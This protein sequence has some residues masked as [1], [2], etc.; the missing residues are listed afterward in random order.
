MP[1]D[2]PFGLE[3]GE[4]WEMALALLG[5]CLVAPGA[6]DGDAQQLCAVFLEYRTDLVVERYLIAED[7]APVRRIEARMTGRT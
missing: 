5:E 7:R 4:Q 1:G 6:I 2:L 3:I